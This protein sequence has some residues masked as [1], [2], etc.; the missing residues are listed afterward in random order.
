MSPDGI[1]FRW[2]N[3]TGAGCAGGSETRPYGTS[4]CFAEESRR[5]SEGKCF[6]LT[7]DGE[8]EDTTGLCRSLGRLAT[9]S[10]VRQVGAS[11]FSSAHRDDRDE[12]RNDQDSPGQDRRKV[13]AV[14]LLC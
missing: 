2:W 8:E 14:V 3:G 9:G 13:P 10:R 12:D 6:G 4:W 1:C 11:C 5:E 7:S